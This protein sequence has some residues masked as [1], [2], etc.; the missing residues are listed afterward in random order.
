MK[1]KALQVNL[2]CTRVDVTVDDQYRILLEVMDR[3]Q[4]VKAGIQTLLEEI[5]HPYKN[6]GYIVKEARSY[7][8]NYFLFALFFL[9]LYGWERLHPERI[10]G[11][12]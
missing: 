12:G 7:A 3:Y 1:S 5:C 8:L 6:W 2:E 9:L 10:E 4:G 11:K